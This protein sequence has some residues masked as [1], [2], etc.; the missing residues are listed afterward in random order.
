MLILIFAERETAM[1]S[2][3]K[4]FRVSFYYLLVIV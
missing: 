2:T 4:E 1:N 3:S